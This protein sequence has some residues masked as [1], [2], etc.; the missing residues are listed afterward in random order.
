M[1]LSR[2]FY[3][4]Q[5]QNVLIDNNS[6]S[7]TIGGLSFS[8]PSGEIIDFTTGSQTLVI[9]GTGPGAIPVKNSKIITVS[10]TGTDGGDFLSISDALASIT[11]ASATNPYVISV[12]PG[13][14]TEPELVM[15]SYVD[16]VGQGRD[17]NFL[18]PLYFTGTMVRGVNNAS[19]KNFTLDGATGSGGIGV[20]A[21]NLNSTQAFYVDTLRFLRC[22]T[23]VKIESTGSGDDTFVGMNDIVLDDGVDFTTGFYVHTA[24]PTGSVNMKVSNLDYI[25]FTP[26]VNTKL[27]HCDGNNAIMNIMNV[28]A[29]HVLPTGDAFYIENGADL[30]LHSSTFN[31][32]GIG[33]HNPSGSTE[34]STFVIGGTEFRCATWNIYIDDSLTDGQYVGK[35]E[36]DKTYIR[37]GSTFSLSGFVKRSFMVSNNAG[38]AVDFHSLSDAVAAITNSSSTNR[39]VVH[40]RPGVYTEPLIDLSTKPYVNVYGEEITSVV[41]QPDGAHDIFKIGPNVELS[42][43][44]LTGAQSGYSAINFTNGGDFGQCHKVAFYDCDTGILVNNTTNV[45]SEFY[46]EYVDFN[47]T[48]MHAVK[49]TSPTGTAFVNLEN[50]YV[51]PTVYVTGSHGVHVEDAGSDVNISSAYFSGLG[52][53]GVH[54]HNGAKI[55]VSNAD[56]EG[57]DVAVHNPNVGAA[58]EVNILST[59]LTENTLELQVLHPSSIGT[60][61]GISNDHTL[62]VTPNGFHVNFIDKL[63]GEF[64][65]D[66]KLHMK[67]EDGTSTDVSTL[68]LKNAPMGLLEGGVITALTGTTIN[69]S[70]GV[71]YVENTI[72]DNVL[73]LDWNSQNLTLPTGSNEYVYINED[74]VLGYSAS[75]PNFEHNIVLGRVVTNNN[76]LIAIDPSPMKIY[77]VVNDMSLFNREA[78]GSVFR[79]GSIVSTSPT[80][81]YKLDVSSGVYYF[82]NNRFAPAGG[83]QITFTTYYR[84]G[85]GGWIHSTGTTVDGTYWDDGTGVLNDIANNHYA[86]HGF[87]LVG[88]GMYEKYF[89]VLGQEEFPDLVSVEGGNLP[90]PPSAIDDGIVNI[91]GIIVKGG[92][93]NIQEI[94]DT[95]PVIGFKASGVAAASNH[96]NLQGLANDDHTQY[97]LVNGGRSMGG[98]LN[99]GTYNITN[100]GTFNSVAVETHASRHLPQGS[101]PLTTLVPSSITTTNTTGSANAFARSDHTHDI[102]LQGLTTVTSMLT[103]DYVAISASGTSYKITPGNFVSASINAGVPSNITTTNTT[104][105]A[106]TWSRSDHTHDINLQ[107]LTTATSMLSTDYVAISASGTSYKII[108][109]NFVSQNINAGTP[110]GITTT[111]ATGSAQTWARSDHTHDINLSGLTTTTSVNTTTDFV[112]VHVTASGAAYKITPSNLLA[113]NIKEGLPVGISNVNATGTAP[114]WARSDH[115]HDINI[116]A[117]STATSS[118][119]GD[120]VPIYIGASGGAYKI[121]PSNLLAVSNT[122]GVPSNIGDVNATGSSVAL[123]RSDHVH[124]LAIPSFPETTGV[125]GTQ[126]YIVMYSSSGAQHQ[127]ISMSNAVLNF[128]GTLTNKSLVDT[129]TYFLKSTDTTKSVQLQAADV[130]TPWILQ[131][132]NASGTIHLDT[133]ELMMATTGDGIH[134][135]IYNPSVR[136]KTYAM[137]SDLL[138]HGELYLSFSTGQGQLTTTYTSNSLG[139]IAGVT[140]IIGTSAQF[141]GATTG[142]F[143]ANAFSTKLNSTG[144]HLFT[145]P[146]F[147]M[148]TYI[149]DYNDFCFHT[150]VTISI[151]NNALGQNNTNYV[152][153]LRI[154]RADGV[155]TF[156]VPG[157]E[158]KQFSA[159]NADWGSTAIHSDLLLNK[160]DSFVLCLKASKAGVYFD[161]GSLNFF[162][163]GMPC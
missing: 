79:S 26:T 141:T 29:F 55:H 20:Y 149:G 128:T 87:Y 127:K 120:F 59:D 40:L 32:F 63:D 64:H 134:T 54:L 12:G 28:S 42:F 117:L 157:S 126:D 56:F 75:L 48:F 94:Q 93:T 160:N 34:A 67:F 57:Y 78:L 14:Y 140:Y 154:I 68:F 98:N 150:A 27:F 118:Q 143:A 51:F 52:Y 80:G 101:D 153:W 31:N 89:L 13:V 11:N 162:S 72:T 53:Y 23:L 44:T 100:A 138:P 35:Y 76:D 131:F 146:K 130:L 145:M 62:I 139:A 74:N 70:T 103:T 50:F 152:F 123:S 109:S 88:D 69:I 43:L 91:A 163:M 37:Q 112:A 148:L 125:S 115:V 107:G 122:F 46:G 85:T 71:G 6:I 47:G 142:C 18:R 36:R 135:I 99:M 104:G 58:C 2:S 77:H 136:T 144:S 129:S 8:V 15:K 159:T 96:S 86:K 3:P 119:G 19:F 21:S 73:R 38:D 84:N 17:V 161:L 133:T 61:Q 22:E 158:I 60:F 110:V 114:T 90:N 82:G 124:S 24:G 81:T 39:Y 155:T 66:S 108:P 65:I 132:P 4:K 105:S 156:D 111:N 95:R 45:A 121:S 5:I 97:L 41:I 10:T 151:K 116:N 9:G 16:I 33:L 25:N 92:G 49:V 106:N 1:S 7:T 102:N 113:S 147:G 83:N 137:M 30:N